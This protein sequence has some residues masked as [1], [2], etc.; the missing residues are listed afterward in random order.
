MIDLQESTNGM[1]ELLYGDKEA[2]LIYALRISALSP[3]QDLQKNGHM[4]RLLAQFT[5]QLLPERETLY[6]LLSVANGYVFHNHMRALYSID[7]A[8]QAGLLDKF[9]TLPSSYEEQVIWR[10]GLVS[11]ID[12]MGEK[13]ISFAALIYS[14]LTCQLVAIDRHHLR[15]LG[16]DP[17]KALR[18]KKYLGVEMSIRAERDHAGYRHVALGVYSAW[19]W[20]CQRDGD[21]TD[22]YPSHRALSC[23][24]Y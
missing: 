19:L 17:N 18:S 2:S 1:A 13:T 9:V 20:A 15:R 6:T 4:A 24:W 8:W 16:L 12:G 3:L 7:K 22:V 11:I 23:R 14:P 5:G 10:N 21:S